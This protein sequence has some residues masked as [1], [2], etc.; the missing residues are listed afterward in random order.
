M[1]KVNAASQ[2]KLIALLQQGTLNCTEL[3]QQSG[4]HYV[5]VL[6]YT[7]EL[8]KAKAAHICQWLKDS[9]GRDAIKIYKLG[10]GLDK[11]RAK[12]TAAERQRAY[13]QRKHEQDTS[14]LVVS[15]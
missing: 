6:N 13:R 10:S 12:M 2:A 11:P 3:A 15:D 8:H 7:R 4:L 5:T 1:V 14:N 9:K